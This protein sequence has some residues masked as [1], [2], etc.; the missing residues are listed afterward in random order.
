VQAQGQNWPPGSTVTYTIDG[1]PGVQTKT[2]AVPATAIVPDAQQFD[3]GA[4]VLVYPRA[5]VGTR[6]LNA[7][8]LSADVDMSPLAPPGIA[9]AFP[10]NFLV[11]APSVNG[12]IGFT[13]RNG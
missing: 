10:F 3:P 12:E 11:Q 8:A 2:F 13:V 1:L 7:I 9:V 6:T 4:S 5:E